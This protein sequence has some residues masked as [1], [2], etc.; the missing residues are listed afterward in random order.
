MIT[1]T[2]EVAAR[3]LAG[4]YYDTLTLEWGKRAARTRDEFIEIAWIN[5]IAEASAIINALR[6]QGIEIP[7]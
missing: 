4:H 3:A 2:I 5:R 6:A 7:E 1:P